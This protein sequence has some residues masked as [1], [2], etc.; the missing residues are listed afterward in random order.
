M[1]KLKLQLL[2]DNNFASNK[3]CFIIFTLLRDQFNDLDE[4]QSVKIDF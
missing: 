3:L 1:N 4:S 2:N